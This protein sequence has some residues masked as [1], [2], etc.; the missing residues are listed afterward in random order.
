M[1]SP[2]GMNWMKYLGANM[3]LLQQW[4]SVFRDASATNFIVFAIRG[5]Q[6]II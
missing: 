4:V 1:I 2:K 6:D 5:T 3:L